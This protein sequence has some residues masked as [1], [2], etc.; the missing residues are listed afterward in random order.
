MADQSNNMDSLSRRSDLRFKI[1][2]LSH[3]PEDEQRLD[4]KVMIDELVKANQSEDFWDMSR[5]EASRKALGVVEKSIE[6]MRK[7]KDVVTSDFLI[8]YPERFGGKL[9]PV[10]VALV[11]VMYGPSVMT[12]DVYARMR[13]EWCSSD[14][15]STWFGESNDTNDY[16]RIAFIPDDE[17]FAKKFENFEFDES[18]N[19]KF[20]ALQRRGIRDLMGLKPE[21]KIISKEKDDSRPTQSEHQ[22]LELPIDGRPT[23]LEGGS[24]E[25][26]Y[27]RLRGGS[28]GVFKPGDGERYLHDTPPEALN[29]LY[30]RERAAFLVD[31]ALGVGLVPTT[32]IRSIDGREGSLQEFIS[33]PHH[34]LRTE[35]ETYDL[36]DQLFNLA[37]LDYCIWNKDRDRDHVLILDDPQRRSEI[38]GIDHSLSFDERFQYLIS[39]N[40]DERVYGKRA[41]IGTV[42]KF[43]AFLTT[44]R[45]QLSLQE[46]LRP[47]L[48]SRAIDATFARIKH[49]GELLVQNR[50]VNEEDLKMRFPTDETDIE[51]Y[52]RTRR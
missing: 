5:N 36:E 29:R 20:L 44:S 35:D 24:N 11:R 8:N 31:Q 27:V 52:P 3:H 30:I 17:K 39:Y 25:V 34:N 15:P 51:Y 14:L 28:A 7:Y 22:L 43:D 4:P 46:K 10:F 45:L 49:I 6:I 32:V 12:K 33:S 40:L 13:G 47:L 26:L 37:V 18:A 2:G 48:P 21:V 16:D 42:E 9:D 41:P 50:R 38:K 1:P 23:R 19:I